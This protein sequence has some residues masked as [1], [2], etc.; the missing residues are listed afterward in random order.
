[1]THSTHSGI[2]FPLTYGVSALYCP[3]ISCGADG[4]SASQ[5]P[6]V[7]EPACWCVLGAAGC[8]SS[9]V[10]VAAASDI[11]DTGQQKVRLV[12]NIL[13]DLNIFQDV[14]STRYTSCCSVSGTLAL[15]AIPICS[16]GKPAS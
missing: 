10:G 11:P 1:M 5:P 13:E 3:I 4:S 8:D 2:L 15:A 12:W 16:A 6:V 7:S 14:L 9:V